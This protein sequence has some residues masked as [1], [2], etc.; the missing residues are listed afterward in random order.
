MYFLRTRDL[1]TEI[2]HCSI[3][4]ETER[5]MKDNRTDDPEIDQTAHSFHR[6]LTRGAL[7]TPTFFRSSRSSGTDTPLPI[8]TSF[9]FPI[10]LPETS[11]SPLFFVCLLTPVFMV[12]SCLHSAFW[13]TGPKTAA[14]PPPRGHHPSRARWF[15]QWVCAPAAR[16]SPQTYRIR[17]SGWAPAIWVLTNP[18]SDSAAPSILR[19][20]L[21]SSSVPV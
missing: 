10:S 6:S 5:V 12:R 14:T 19:T 8:F 16:A 18:S 9:Y 13:T 7:V 20:P 4:S 3:W 21:L 17:N 15:S 11:S 2:K 1:P